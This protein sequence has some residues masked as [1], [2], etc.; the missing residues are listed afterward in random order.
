MAQKV[1]KGFKL[2]VEGQFTAEAGYLYFVRTNTGATDGYLQFDGKKY[3]TAADAAA[4]LDAKI[5]T[6]PEGYDSVV[7]YITAQVSA[8][9]GD[10]ATK[11]EVG[12]LSGRV[13]TLSAVSAETRIAALEEVSADTPLSQSTDSSAIPFPLIFPPVIV[14]AP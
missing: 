10:Y 8:I 4:E 1:F 9:T 3:G 13:D 7:E 6:L 5:G 11:E 2:E 12:T 14:K